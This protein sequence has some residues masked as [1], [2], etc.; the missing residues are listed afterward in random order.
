MKIFINMKKNNL[1]LIA[2]SVIA[3]FIWTNAGA[4]ATITTR[5]WKLSDFPQK[6]TKIVMTGNE[7]LDQ[8][9]KEEA[10]SRWSISPYE[11]CTLDEF[12]AL[13]SSTDY[14]FLMIVKG[15]YKKETQ[16]GINLLTLVKGGAPKSDSGV[17]E[18]YEVISVPFSAVT[19]GAGRE[20]IFMPAMIDL[21]QALITEALNHGLRSDSAVKDYSINITKATNKRILISEDDLSE[22]A[23]AFIGKDF[24]NGLEIVSEDDADSTFTAQPENTLVSYVVAPLEPEKGSYCYK[25]LFDAKTH[26]LYYFTKTKASSADK[27]GFTKGDIA[28][29]ASIE[30]KAEN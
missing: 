7:I 8:T 3:L 10:I 13:K 26:Q 12:N 30:S 16:P 27:V 17:N 20:L 19:P 14:Y 18:M 2:L 11:F 5:K 1:L 6:T 21:M 23:K 4:Q 22:K 9:F 29:L 25:M 24:E 28:T 15:Q